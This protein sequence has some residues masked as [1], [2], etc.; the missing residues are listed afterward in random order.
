M[1]LENTTIQLGIIWDQVPDGRQAD[2]LRNHPS[3]A[4]KVFAI[5]K[6]RGLWLRPPCPIPRVAI[7]ALQKEHTARKD[8]WDA[9]RFREGRERYAAESHIDF[10]LS[11]TYAGTSRKY[12]EA[13]RILGDERDEARIRCE[14]SAS[15]GST[16]P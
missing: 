10:K 12:L 4:Q 7:I 15:D 6:L 14:Q 3:F 5:D 8:A 9:K 2:G 13:H 16:V 11:F 1:L